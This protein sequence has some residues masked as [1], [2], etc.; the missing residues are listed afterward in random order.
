M[1]EVVTGLL[2]SLIVPL[3]FQ[4]SKW[5]EETEYKRA[6]VFAEQTLSVQLPLQTILPRGYSLAVAPIPSGLRRRRSRNSTTGHEMEDMFEVERCI[7][8]CI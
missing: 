4:I 7:D 3:C 8:T 1:T 5:K 2:Y 6:H